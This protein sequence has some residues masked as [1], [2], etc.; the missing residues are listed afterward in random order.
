MPRL[1]HTCCVIGGSG[2]IGTALVPLLVKTGRN[3]V[4]VGRRDTP[5]FALPK[6]ARYIPCDYGDRERLRSVLVGV[7]EIIDLA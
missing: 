2:F 5:A 6:E 1:G 4:V 7:S 3:V